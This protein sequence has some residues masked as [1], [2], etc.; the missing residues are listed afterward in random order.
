MTLHG[1]LRKPASVEIMGRTTPLEIYGLAYTLD[2]TQAMMELFGW[3]N[4]PDF[5]PVHFHRVDESEL[6]VVLE[7]D[8]MRILAS[9]VK[10]L[11]PTIGLRIEFIKAGKVVTYSCDTEPCPQVVRLAHNANVLIHEATG[12]QVGHSSPAQAAGIAKQAGAQALYLIHYSPEADGDDLVRQARDGFT[13]PVRLA[14]DF[15]VLEYQ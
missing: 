6:A 9:P 12:E 14:H 10:H 11:I 2:R 4:W 1:S 13:G 8:E 15:M 7:T 5:Y 3:Q